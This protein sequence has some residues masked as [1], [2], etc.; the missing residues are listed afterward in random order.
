MTVAA[1]PAPSPAAVATL[2]MQL[3]TQ[4]DSELAVHRRLIG[5]AETKLRQ[6]VSHDVPGFSQTLGREQTEHTEAGRLRQVRDRLL[7]AIAVVLQLGP[8]E[9]TLSRLAER[10]SEP[11]RAEL[12]HRQGELKQALER[13]G[14]L[15]D[16]AQSLIRH[17][18]TLVR[19]MLNAVAGGGEAVPAGPAYDRR[20][21]Q[22]A[23]G[24]RRG[25]LLDI[26]S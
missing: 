19:D 22:G 10:A 2:L 20:G 7:R 17:S 4:L 6:L 15:N 1:H 26:R 21:M 18:I 12:R 16:R 23:Y 11:L 14:E 9:L 13:L 3:R 8:G 25:S 5:L 24:P